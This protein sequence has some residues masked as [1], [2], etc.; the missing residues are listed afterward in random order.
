MHQVVP[1]AGRLCEALGVLAEALAGGCVDE[2]TYDSCWTGDGKAGAMPLTLLST[3]E[4][5]KATPARHDADGLGMHRWEDNNSLHSWVFT[6]RRV[7]S[8]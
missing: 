3:G 4:Q 5:S 7:P 6:I 1:A 2:F 8:P